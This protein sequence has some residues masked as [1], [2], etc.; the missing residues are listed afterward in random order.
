MCLFACVRE[1]V[2]ANML[3]IGMTK[4]EMPY[5]HDNGT[6]LYAWFT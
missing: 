3:F 1:C 6:V 4:A 2:L 5:V